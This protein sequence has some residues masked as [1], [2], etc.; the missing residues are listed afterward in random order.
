MIAAAA[1]AVKIAGY[2]LMCYAIPLAGLFESDLSAAR[3]AGTC[4]PADPPA[5]RPCAGHPPA[6][7]R[8]SRDAASGAGLD[9]SRGGPA[10]R[11]LGT[12]RSCPGEA[13]ITELRE[14]DMGVLVDVVPNHMG[15]GTGTN[16]WWHDVLENG[17]SSLYARVF[18]IDWHPLKPELEGKVLLPVLGDAYGAVHVLM[19]PSSGYV[20]HTTGEVTVGVIVLFLIFGAIS[21][22]IWAYFRYRPERWIPKRAR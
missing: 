17:P 13:R 7:N 5:G 22:G 8:S 11:F 21:V 3:A 19:S 2:L 6:E 10:S 18:D 20:G 16:A 9:G 14:R 1:T 4:S 15:I 12:K